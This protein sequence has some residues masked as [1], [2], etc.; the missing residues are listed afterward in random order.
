L[1]DSQGEEIQAPSGKYFRSGDSR[2]KLPPVLAA[3]HGFAI[4]LVQQAAPNEEADDPLA[5]GCL[6]GWP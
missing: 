6:P 1:G 5:Q 2:E 4:G 3:A